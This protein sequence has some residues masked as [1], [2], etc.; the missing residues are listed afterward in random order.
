MLK[1]CNAAAALTE[2]EVW[3]RCLVK[4]RRRERNSQFED[5]AAALA[6]LS[7]LT[8]NQSQALLNT[9][10]EVESEMKSVKG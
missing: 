4:Q 3:R 1:Q 2:Q 10:T 7:D 8:V 9:S 5:L 6:L